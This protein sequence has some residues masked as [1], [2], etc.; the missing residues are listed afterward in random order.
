M[1]HHREFQTSTF[2]GAG[3]GRASWIATIS[4]HIPPCSSFALFAKD[5]LP[6]HFIQIP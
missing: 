6:Q 5:T 3:V 4:S 2:S 1:S